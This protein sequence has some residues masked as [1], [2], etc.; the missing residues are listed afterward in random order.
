MGRTMTDHTAPFRLLKPGH[1]RAALVLTSAHS[2]RRYDPA[3]LAA[4]RLDATEIRRS[5]DS[6]VDELF[7]A[8]PEL[9]VPLLAAQF[10]RAYCDANREA[11][12]LDPLMFADVLPAHVNT[13][14]P[15]VQAGLGTI[16]RIVG[17]GEPI[18]TGK[19]RFAEAQARVETCW[20]PF[21]EALAGQIE[22]TLALFGTCLVIDCHSMPSLPGRH[23]AKADIVLGDGFGTSC[24]PAWTDFLHASLAALGFQVRRNDPYAGGFITRHY[25]RP[26]EGVQ[27]IQLEMARGLYMNEQNF[28][29][30]RN[31][32]EIQ[33]RM[34][35]LLS[36]VIEARA[37]WEHFL[38]N[39]RA[40]AAE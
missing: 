9:G 11:W 7:A 37:I 24:A 3:F 22:E 8:G 18:Y 38:P 40:A 4:S 23:A 27:V 6:F 32:S 17:N 12:E 29:H 1:R 34:T 14:S 25:G 15:R 19:L 39:C 31:F 26:R 35:A 33:R 10:P 21:H 36:K 20:L 30:S 28:T 13:T 16:A 5:E 2:G